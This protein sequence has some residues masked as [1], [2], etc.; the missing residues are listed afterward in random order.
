MSKLCWQYRNH[1]RSCNILDRYELIGEAGIGV[2]RPPAVEF[3]LSDKSVVEPYNK[4]KNFSIPPLPK[5]RFPQPA[6]GGVAIGGGASQ[7]PLKTP[8]RPLKDLLRGQCA[9]RRNPMQKQY[10]LD[11]AIFM[12]PAFPSPAGGAP[13]RLM[14]PPPPKTPWQQ[15]L[16]PPPSPAT[17]SPPP[18]SPLAT[19]SPASVQS[20]TSKSVV[21]PSPTSCSPTPGT[22]TTIL[23]PKSPT[24]SSSTP[25]VWARQHSVDS[26]FQRRPIGI[27]KQSS[28]SFPS[29]HTSQSSPPKTPESPATPPI[30]PVEA[31]PKLPAPTAG[32]GLVRQAS[33]PPMP[34]CP[35]PIPLT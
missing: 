16:S 27:P 28:Q 9:N 35:P 3:V 15:L 10:S 18:W 8:E 5:T 31:S 13:T 32:P 29:L 14:T 30:S 21:P 23:K 20:P 33:L 6:G 12:R 34:M 4:F 26:P 24:S 19:A 11:P 17:K 1:K 2:R 22:P 25:P 7:V